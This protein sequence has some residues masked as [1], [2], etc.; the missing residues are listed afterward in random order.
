[1]LLSSNRRCVLGSGRI[2]TLEGALERS[3]NV[4]HPQKLYRFPGGIRSTV[5]ILNS[6]SCALVVD[7][8]S[9]KVQRGNGHNCLCSETKWCVVPN[10][11]TSGWTDR[12]QKKRGKRERSRAHESET[13]RQ[14][15]PFAKRH[16]K[17]PEHGLTLKNSVQSMSN[18]PNA[19]RT[20]KRQ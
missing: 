14:G 9:S 12:I 2:G 16:Y 10:T 11:S 7:R 8:N 5:D 3:S 19:T 15:L 17:S 13:L 4:E 18:Q 20:A 6:R 1:M